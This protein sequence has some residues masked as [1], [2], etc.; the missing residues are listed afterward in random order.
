MVDQMEVDLLVA[1]TCCCFAV[2]GMEKLVQGGDAG[3][4]FFEG[5]DVDFDVRVGEKLVGDGELDLRL[6]VLGLG[7]K[8]HAFGGFYWGS[9][10]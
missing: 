2:L 5:G 9:H 6:T 3:T 7:E 8:E 4:E 1:D 10:F